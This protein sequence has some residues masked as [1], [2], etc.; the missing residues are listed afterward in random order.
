MNGAA[1]FTISSVLEFMFRV[2]TT[3]VK[4][5]N[6]IIGHVS[7]FMMN[8]F[9][10]LEKSFDR[11]FHHE[12]M[13]KNISPRMCIGVIWF[14][15]QNVAFGVFNFTAFPAISVFHNGRNLQCRI[16]EFNRIFG[17][18]QCLPGP[19]SVNL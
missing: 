18:L 10:A 17:G 8:R 3:Q 19:T 11:L 15:H 5:F 12:A 1:L 2:A 9:A 16:K 13:L 4:I 7:V 14:V 6:S